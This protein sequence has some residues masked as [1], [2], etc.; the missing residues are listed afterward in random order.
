MKN[1]DAHNDSD[2][3]R[4]FLRSWRFIN[5]TN[6]YTIKFCNKNIEV[7]NICLGKYTHSSI[8]RTRDRLKKFSMLTRVDDERNRVTLRRITLCNHTRN[9]FE[10]D[11]IAWTEFIAPVT[12]NC[13]FLKQ[14]PKGHLVFSDRKLSDD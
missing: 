12:K 4:D 10:S 1:T 9:L 3:L 13:N 5:N 2:V 7:Y 6:I 14:S 8:A 11:W